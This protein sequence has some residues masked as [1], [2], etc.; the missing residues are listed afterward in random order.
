MGAGGRAGAERGASAVLPR[1]DVERA[2]A[3]FLFLFS[4][5]A[6][7]VCSADLTR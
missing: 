2:P 1:S 6:A 3:S 7:I 5:S 4:G